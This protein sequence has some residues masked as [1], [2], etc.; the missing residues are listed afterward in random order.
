MEL[1]HLILPLLIFFARIVDVSLGTIRVI[2]VSKGFRLLAPLL[3]F[4]EILIWIIAV[5]EV[6]SSYSGPLVYIAY[7]AGFAMGNYVGICLEDKMSI[8]RVMVRIIT[9]E[10]AG[11]LIDNLKNKKYPL[12]ITDARGRS[13]DVKIIFSVIK[14]KKLKKMIYLINK[15]NPRAF[16]SV[17]DI[18]S[19]KEEDFLPHRQRKVFGFSRKSK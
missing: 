4:F 14:K 6:M 9:Q 5:K 7:A 11:E 3:G 1:I 8:G 12:T 15:T 17:E 16:Y 2:F 19:A 13:G 10:H 18:R